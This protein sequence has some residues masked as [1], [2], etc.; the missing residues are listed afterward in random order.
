MD[1]RHIENNKYWGSR[2]W[3]WAGTSP[4]PKLYVEAKIFEGILVEKLAGPS[5]QSKATSVL[6]FSII[7]TK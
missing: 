5:L 2:G 7:F 6:T 1:A 4:M 3:T